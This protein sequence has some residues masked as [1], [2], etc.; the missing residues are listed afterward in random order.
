MTSVLIGDRRGKDRHPEEKAVED[1]GRD[2]SGVATSGA[3][4]ATAR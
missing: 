2:W 3:P 4:G 1:K